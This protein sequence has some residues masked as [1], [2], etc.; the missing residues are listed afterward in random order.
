MKDLRDRR[1]R[2]LKRGAGTSRASCRRTAWCRGAAGWRSLRWCRETCGLRTPTRCTSCRCCPTGHPTRAPRALEHRRR[3]AA[4]RQRRTW[5][6][7][8]SLGAC[9]RRPSTHAECLC[10]ASWP[11]SRNTSGPWLAQCRSVKLAAVLITPQD[12]LRQARRLTCVVHDQR[13]CSQLCCR[14]PEGRG[15]E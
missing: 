11:V 8:A 10:E 2:C 14:R 12:Y 3:K 5:Y 1:S 4:V 9:H 6:C 13:L 15:Q 7:E